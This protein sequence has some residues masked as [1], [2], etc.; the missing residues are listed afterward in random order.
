MTDAKNLEKRL[1][2]CLEQTERTQQVAEMLITHIRR[3]SELIE[4]ESQK[5][6]CNRQI[7]YLQSIVH[8]C[9]SEADTLRELIRRVRG[10]A[11]KRAKNPAPAAPYTTIRVLVPKGLQIP[12]EKIKELVLQTLNGYA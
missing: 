5:E 1:K 4:D 6:D 2:A 9:E 11:P 10:D 3:L 8:S 7:R 12:D